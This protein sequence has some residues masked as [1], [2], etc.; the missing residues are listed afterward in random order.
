MKRKIFIPV[1]TVLLSVGM[2][3]FVSS[4]MDNEVNAADFSQFKAGNI[5]SDF[6][7]SNK[8]SMS[9]ADISNFIRSK[10]TCNRPYDST[11][12]YYEGLGYQYHIKNGYVV[13]IAD[14]YEWFGNK[15]AAN[16][17]YRASQDYNINPQVLLV[18]IHKE[19]GLLSDNWPNFNS[20]YAHA[21]GFGCP[22][23]AAC[24]PAYSGFEMQVRSAASLYRE[25]LSGGWTNY[26]VGWNY[27]QYNPNAACGGTNVYIEN[28]ATSALY[29]FTPYQ[30]NPATLSV[31]MGAT[32]SCGAYG[33]K[34]FYG[35]FTDWF[36]S[37]QGY[38]VHG[39]IKERYDATNKYLGVAI[40][41]EICTLVNNGCY[42]V[43]EKGSIYWTAEHGGWDVRGGIKEYWSKLKYENG[44]MGYPISG[45][46]CSRTGC[47]QEYQGGRIYWRDQDG[48][49]DVHGGIGERYKTTGYANGYYGYPLSNEICNLK[50]KGCYQVFERGNF[51]WTEETNAWDMR[52]GIMAR[53]Y[54]VGFENGYLGYPI[55][56]E[57][58]DNG[59]V[60]QKFQNG[61]I[62]W[63]ASIDGWD[64]GQTIYDQWKE[65]K[66]W[67]GNPTSRT[68][69]GLINGG[70]YQT[71]NNGS[72]YWTQE[73][74]SWSIHGGIKAHWITLGS[75]WGKA[76]YPTTG[77][78]KDNNSVRQDFEKGSIYWAETKGAWFVAK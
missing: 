4:K 50:D 73:H 16:I 72:M 60:Y 13:C 61:V 27:V 51:Y 22:D 49:H 25:V 58:L 44:R 37:T 75:E 57:I 1:I 71:F 11:V 68:F 53:W 26:P 33:N 10:I 9:E 38:A 55:S 5:M 39:G 42:Q 8:A 35:Y 47:Y 63:S 56:T 70:C 36:G 66:A 62:Y 65:S 54:T 45:E 41:P 67:L 15:T 29:R 69:C 48:A 30:P 12:K 14:E 31:P 28:R 19:Q 64:M 43:F 7:M 3:F 76:G 77:E 40:S 46:I 17:I 6:V 2:G 24:D 78:Y 20:Q 21:T 32:V 18:L 34:N 59:G 74:G 52:G 23:T